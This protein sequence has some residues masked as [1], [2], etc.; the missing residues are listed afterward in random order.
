MVHARLQEL[1]A[2]IQVEFYS[3]QHLH[4]G[5]RES[6]HSLN[7]DITRIP[8]EALRDHPLDT[9]SVEEWMKWTSDCQTTEEEDGAYCLLGIFTNF[10]PLI[11]GEGKSSALRRLQ[12]ELEVIPATGIVYT[13][14][15]TH[16]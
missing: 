5:D 8:I 4:L 12:R 3:C 6:L 9:F 15:F 16:R 7:H 10:M 2:S 1:L 11:Y 14:D 13:N